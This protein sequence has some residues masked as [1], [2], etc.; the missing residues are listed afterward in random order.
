[1][2]GIRRALVYATVTRYVTWA[3][4]LGSTPII[5]RLMTSAESAIAVI[6]GAVFGIAMAA[7]ELGSVAYLV[8]QEDL[9]LDKI[10]NCLHR[11]HSRYLHCRSLARL[12]V[13]S[14]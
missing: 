10:P 14:D 12:A 2:V 5:A 13:R 6:G 3:V 7:R 9:S 8:R 11:K 4:T 1:M